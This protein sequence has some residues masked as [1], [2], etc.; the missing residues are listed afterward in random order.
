MQKVTNPD[1]LSALEGGTAPVAEAPEQEPQAAGMR[2]VTDPNVLAQL[3]Q[4]QQQEKAVPEIEPD[5]VETELSPV[6]ALN[7]FVGAGEAALSVMSS[8]VAE[9]IAGLYGTVATAATGGDT[10]KGVEALEAARKAFTYVPKTAEGKADL[11]GVGEFIQPVAE[12]VERVNRTL[13]D[14]AYDVTGSPTAA[15]AAYAFP[16]LIAEAA[17]VRGL[18][19]LSRASPDSRRLRNAQKAMLED[20]VFKYSGDVAAVKLNNKGQVVPDTKGEQLLDLGFNNNSVAVVTNSTPETKKVMGSMLDKFDAGQSNDIIAATSKMS[21]D[22]GK[23]VTKRINV[24]GGR[25]KNLGKRLDKLVESDLRDVTVPLEQPIG[26]F[27]QSLQKD[28]GV[29]LSIKRDGT[30]AMNDVAGTPLSTRG[31]SSVRNLIED[32]VEL[33]NQKAKGGTANARDAHKLKKLMDELADSQKASEMGLSNNTH[34]RMLALRQGINQQLQTASPKYARINS[35]LS[36]SIEAMKPFTKYLKEG[37]TWSDAKVSDVVGAAMKNIGGDTGS[38][39]ALRTDIAQL[40]AA[41]RGMGFRFADDPRALVTFK[42]T[43]E[44]YFQLD[45]EALLKQ[46]GKYDDAISSGILDAGSSLAVGNKFGFVHDVAKLR[47][48]G[49]S[50]SKAQDLVRNK[51]EAK[52]ALR[53]ALK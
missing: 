8:M 30:F 52:D 28:F 24:I 40:E 6:E 42:K 14:F 43:V 36:K 12:A 23:A 10:N 33:M 15:A 53:E 31:L 18:R 2:R 17:G 35:E 45:A 13:G 22:I 37:Q 29:K 11:Q 34:R 46:T 39:A 32:T 49:V 4:E 27:F 25:R 20:D 1:L 41:V 3:Q 47:K 44:D 50:K 38:S 26:E 51:I 19:S 16:T 9:P 48:L 5:P 21:D 7:Q